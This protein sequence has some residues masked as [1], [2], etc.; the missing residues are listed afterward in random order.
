MKFIKKI[1]IFAILFNYQIG[2]VGSSNQ[3][4]LPSNQIGLDNIEYFAISNGAN[5]NPYEFPN[6]L[7]K[8]K[9]AFGSLPKGQNISI[10]CID[11]TT[12]ASPKIIMQATSSSSTNVVQSAPLAPSATGKYVLSF[13]YPFNSSIGMQI[14]SA[15]NFQG[16]TNLTIIPYGTTTQHS[17]TN[18]LPTLQQNLQNLQ[19]GE[20]LELNIVNG[21]LTL[22]NSYG[23]T[24]GK[25]SAITASTNGWYTFYFS[26]PYNNSFV[27]ESNPI[28]P[29]LQALIVTPA[30]NPLTFPANYTPSNFFKSL[31]TQISTLQQGLTITL[32][33]TPSNTQLG[34]QAVTGTTV[35]AKSHTVSLNGAQ[36][37]AIIGSN[38]STSFQ[39][40]YEQNLQQLTALQILP[41][42]AGYPYNVQNLLPILQQALKTLQVGES[43]TLNFVASTNS[44]SVNLQLIGPDGQTVLGT[45][46]DIQQSSNNNYIVVYSLP[47]SI[48][49]GLN[50][51]QAAQSTNLPIIEFSSIADIWLVSNGWSSLPKTCAMLSLL[52]PNQVVTLTMNTIANNNVQIQSVGPDGQTV[53]ENSN[54]IPYNNSAAIAFGLAANK[55]CSFRNLSLQSMDIGGASITATNPF[56]SMINSKAGAL[57]KMQTVGS[58]VQ[59]FDQTGTVLSTYSLTSTSNG[60]IMFMNYTG[61]VQLRYNPDLQSIFEADDINRLVTFIQ[62]NN[63][64]AWTTLAAFPFHANNCSPIM[65]AVMNNAQNCVKYL[66]ANNVSSI[67]NSINTPN[68]KNIT[69]LSFAQTNNLYELETILSF[70]GATA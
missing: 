35:V 40:S 15:M 48:I 18:L 21:S 60:V 24:L 29:Y 38:C 61:P 20:Y 31:K 69:P 41:T 58:N 65:L 34:L 39:I 30:N 11:P 36:P 43:L 54:P 62:Q 32:Q 68:A 27:L 57:L 46:G 52:Q 25:S 13:G 67:K 23:Q 70:F 66:L 9:T 10:S 17:V 12:N 6:F 1:G 55:P 22:T 64:F 42:G 16:L 4:P 5:Q 53:I 45:T 19:A 8:I 7:N 56:L 49:Q 44:G 63:T 33:V 2:V 47:F 28:L 14:T 50:I 59:L 51:T 3:A 26:M 37:I